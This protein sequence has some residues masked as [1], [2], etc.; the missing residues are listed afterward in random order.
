[1]VDTP[2]SVLDAEDLCASFFFNPE[3]LV[4]GYVR[5]SGNETQTHNG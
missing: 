2:G 5:E 1:M 4:F 3:G